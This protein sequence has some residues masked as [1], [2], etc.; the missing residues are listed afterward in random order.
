MRSISIEYIVHSGFLYWEILRILALSIKFA[1]H[2][3]IGHTSDKL[4]YDLQVYERTNINTRF[5]DEGRYRQLLGMNTS[6][7]K[8][9]LNIM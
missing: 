2:W 3:N 6:Q 4:Q 5:Y 1:L 9:A 7:S 8:N